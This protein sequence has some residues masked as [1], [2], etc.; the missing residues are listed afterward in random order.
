MRIIACIENP[1]VI[2]KMLAHLDA[3]GSEPEA[4][5]RLSCRAPLQRELFDETRKLTGR[6]W[7]TGTAGVRA[8]TARQSNARRRPFTPSQGRLVG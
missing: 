1:V 3:Q 5:R 6:A 4:I 2:E 7:D 8:T